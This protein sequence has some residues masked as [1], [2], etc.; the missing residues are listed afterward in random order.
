MGNSSRQP[1]A[2]AGGGN[3]S[4]QLL[5]AAAQPPARQPV[6]AP[7][8]WFEVNPT[9]LLIAA[10]LCCSWIV[11]GLRLHLFTTSG[12][13]GVFL[14]LA[15]GG[16]LG[17]SGGSGP[18]QALSAAAAIL[19]YSRAVSFSLVGLSLQTWLP[20]H[21]ALQAAG[22]G[23]VL[24]GQYNSQVCRTEPLT[25]P[26]ARAAIDWA[27]RS[28]IW[29]ALPLPAPLLAVFQP[30]TP[31]SRCRAVLALLQLTL[32]L[33]LPVA[34]AAVREARECAAWRAERRRAGQRR[35]GGLQAVMYG[36]IWPGLGMGPRG[37]PLAAALY[38]WLLLGELWY[39]AVWMTVEAAAPACPTRD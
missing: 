39:L 22:I 38:I 13:P 34:L 19:F 8:A 9:C 6:R 30:G 17:S 31:A 5:A 15:R 24:A 33:A 32:G 10:L 4:R 29:L 7:E 25:S 14:A 21:A 26:A 3:S 1:L 12:M 35:P 11:A 16:L 23:I 28:A 20:L 2:A 18:L 27:Y 36:A 37:R